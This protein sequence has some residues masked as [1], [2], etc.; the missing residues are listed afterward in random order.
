VKDAVFLDLYRRIR[1]RDDLLTAGVLFRF[2]FRVENYVRNKPSYPPHD[3]WAALEVAV[4][5]P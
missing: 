1:E 3:S 4:T 2:W 5:V